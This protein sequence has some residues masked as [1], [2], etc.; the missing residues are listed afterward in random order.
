MRLSDFVLRYRQGEGEW[1]VHPLTST[2]VLIGRSDDNDLMLQHREV[3]RHHLRLSFHDE[4]F[5]VTD[6]ESSNGTQVDGTA[7]LPQV[8]NDVRPGQM[9]AVGDFT[10]MLEKA[11][12]GGTHISK[13]LL[14]FLLRYRFGVGTWQTF[15]MEPGEKIFA[16]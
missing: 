15:P 12:E 16:S 4:Y 2:E 11:T 3:S 14:P 7:L 1:Q 5:S 13:E 10:L 8:P 9:I 6:L